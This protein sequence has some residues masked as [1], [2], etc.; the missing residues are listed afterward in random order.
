M[1]ALEFHVVS[2]DYINYIWTFKLIVKF[3][4]INIL[5]WYLN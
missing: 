3:E 4:L 1:F 2:L 5:V